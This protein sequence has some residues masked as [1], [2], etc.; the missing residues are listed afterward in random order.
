VSAS[1]DYILLA[2]FAAR[3]ADGS[4]CLLVINKSPSTTLTGNI[5][6]AGYAPSGTINAYSYGIPQDDA[7]RTGVGSADIAA[8]SYS[9]AGSSFA[10]NFPAYSVTV[11]SLN[12]AGAPPPPPTRRPDA[13]IKNSSDSA[14]IG[15]NLY[16]ADGSNQTK[17]QTVRAGKSVT[18]DIVVQNDGS[19]SDSFIVRGSA[20]ATA[21]AVKYYTGLSGGTDVTAAVTAGTYAIS[22]LSAGG[23]QTLRVVVTAARNAAS[24]TSLTC[25]VTATSQGDSSKLDAVKASTTVR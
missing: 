8:S 4:L 25:V 6:I 17:S 1:S 3:R 19:A 21:L 22:N 18:Y 13:L 12:S 2:P 7:A 20:G 10:Y 14:Y 11:L 15:D 9:G 5:N 24:N 16:N 23:S